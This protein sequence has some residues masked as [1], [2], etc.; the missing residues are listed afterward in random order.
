M[1]QIGDETKAKI[2]GYLES[3]IENLVITYKDREV[4]I[5]KNSLEYLSKTSSEGNLKPFHAAMIPKEI[6][7]IT[8]FER[9]FSTGLGS[10]FEECARLIALEHHKDARR[11]YVIT[12][13][14]STSTISE[15]EHQVSLFESAVVTGTTRPTFQSM[16]S[17]VLQSGKQ[18]NQEIRTCRADLYILGNDN[19]EYF[20]EIK[21][22]KPN[23][24]QCLEVL[25]RLLRIQL[26]KESS[27]NKIRTYF[28]MAY[29]PYGKKREQYKWSFARNYFP[30]NEA[31]LI[32]HEFWDIVGGSSTQLEL[33]EIYKE[34]GRERTKYMLDQLAFGF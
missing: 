33:L 28:A 21:S 24:G 30:F 1:K 32:G 5:F 34:V 25:Q 7:K 15:I 20:F 29:N 2:K 18:G 19:T 14:I 10:T 11:D 26:I 4:E 9:G 3:F 22:P 8:A 12:R 27:S 31:L 17:D 13:E 6:L 23:K 16:I